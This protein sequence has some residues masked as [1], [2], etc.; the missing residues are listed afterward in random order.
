MYAFNFCIVIGPVHKIPIGIAHNSYG[1][2]RR[3]HDPNDQFNMPKMILCVIP[4]YN[5]TTHNIIFIRK[6]RTVN[7]F[8]CLQGWTWILCQ[9][10]VYT[11]IYIY[12]ICVCPLPP[13]EIFKLKI[14]YY[15][16][17]ITM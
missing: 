17:Y 13:R 4:I 10:N 5:F 2:S 16:W 1:V 15:N 11:F 7:N 9:I 12:R 8:S 3:S 14:I 6:Y